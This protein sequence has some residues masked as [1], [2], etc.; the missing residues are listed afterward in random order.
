MGRRADYSHE[1][2]GGV[3]PLTD[4]IAAANFDTYVVYCNNQIEQHKQLNSL[5]PQLPR[6]RNFEFMQ[7]V[8]SQ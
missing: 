8:I 3:S 6:V 2:W 5:I 7:V 1:A 4:R